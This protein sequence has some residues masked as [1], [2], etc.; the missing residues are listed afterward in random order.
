MSELRWNAL[1]DEWVITATH[2][3]N[4]TYHP[5]AHYCPLCPTR[6]GAMETEIPLPDFDI[7][8]F[9]N[10]FPSLQRRPPRPAVK[11]NRLE[12][13][14]PARGSCEVVVYTPEHDATLAQASEERILHLIQVW[15]D[16]YREL[17]RRPDVKYVLIFENKGEVIGV[18]LAHPHGQIYAFPFIPPLPSRE[19]KTF[20]RH[21][22][23]HQSCLLCAMAAEERRRKARLVLE[24]DAFTAYIPFAARYPYEVHLLPRRHIGDILAL[25][26]SEQRAWA[27]A[28]KRLLMGY[29]RL[30][31]FSLPY[32]MLL[33]QR[34]SDGRRHPYFHFHVEFL[35]PH[36]TA[37]KLKYLA[38]CE[39]GAGT[40]INDTLAEEK[41]AELRRAIHAGS[42]HA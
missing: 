38:G 34:P 5:P 4:R 6:P 17:G 25:T 40:F 9:E 2:R 20:R 15:R 13:A 32:M 24:N 26:E 35:P 7:A 28:L 21:W 36:R 27:A 3:Q 31:G 41:A 22:K 42:R 37:T 23:E 16:R 18:T 1:L 30:F 10:K 14:L 19:L 39:S 11:G 29:D 12:P 8:V 33:H